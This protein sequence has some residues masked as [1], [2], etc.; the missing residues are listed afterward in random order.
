MT[1]LVITQNITV[2][3]RVEMLGDWFDPADQTPDVLE[4]LHR[5]DSTC[6][7]V[8]LGRRTFESFRGYWPA[9]TDDE[10]GVTNQLNQV[11]KYVAT[12]TLTDPGWVNS[13]ILTGDVIDEVGRIKQQPGRDMVATGSISLCHDLIAAGLVDEYRLFIY[14]VVQGRGRALFPE[15]HE[16]PTLELVDHLAFSNGV[17]CMRYQSHTGNSSATT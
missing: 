16:I 17:A 7:A 6:D 5:Q 2:D 4:E 3:G 8:L 9:Q 11:A 10:T 15:G 1:R 14:P 13:T 12:S